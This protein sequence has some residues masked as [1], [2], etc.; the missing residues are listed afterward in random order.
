MFWFKYFIICFVSSTAPLEPFS[1]VCLYM[2]IIT[3]V[4]VHAIYMHSWVHGNVCVC[5][6]LSS[7][8]LCQDRRR[9]SSNTHRIPGKNKI[10][11]FYTGR[12]LAS[13]YY[14]IPALCSVVQLVAFSKGNMLN[15]LYGSRNK[16]IYLGNLL[17]RVF[18][19]FQCFWCSWVH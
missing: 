14:H 13:T 8:L 15:F 3:N 18:R 12:S 9:L 17:R 7:M 4:W 11:R 6:M 1:H 19:L 16:E 5:V 10:H 2:C